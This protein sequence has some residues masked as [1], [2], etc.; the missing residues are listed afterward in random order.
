MYQSP[1]SPHP[2]P[3]CYVPRSAN[4]SRPGDRSNTWRTIQIMQLLTTQFS[5]A[6]LLL[7]LSEAQS[8]LSTLSSS[9]L[10]LCSSLNLTHPPHNIRHSYFSWSLTMRLKGYP[11]TSHLSINITSR[12][13]PKE[14]QHQ[15][16]TFKRFQKHWKESYALP[17]LIY[18]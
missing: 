10:S 15:H 17:V 16:K 11:E 18:P 14:L 6:F 4:H 5:P 12:H 9:L 8:S 3:T 7:P 1:S 2:H 13:N